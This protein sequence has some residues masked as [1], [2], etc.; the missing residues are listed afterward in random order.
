VTS[1]DGQ[2]LTKDKE[3][4]GDIARSLRRET[5]NNLNLE[6][7]GPLREQQ[8]QTTSDK[9]VID[10]ALSLNQVRWPYLDRN[11]YNRF[12]SIAT[13]CLFRY[14]NLFPVECSTA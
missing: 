14:F 12:H 2:L 13:F 3:K 5:L 4:I 9:A 7:C 8:H 10:S 6:M 1:D 11:P